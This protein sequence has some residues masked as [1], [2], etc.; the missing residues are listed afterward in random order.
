V[1]IEA[2]AAHV[3]TTT[4]LPFFK[5]LVCHKIHAGLTVQQPAH[6]A[7]TLHLIVLQS[8]PCSKNSSS[9]KQKE[10]MGSSYPQ[11]KHTPSLNE[12]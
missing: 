1:K 7:T 10:L 9:H 2:T 6:S 4:A 12:P 3:E 8:R 5:P 11:L